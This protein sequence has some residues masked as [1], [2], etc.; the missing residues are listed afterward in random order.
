M[1]YLNCIVLF[2]NLVIRA[3]SGAVF[4]ALVILSILAP[5]PYYF[6]V[7]FLLIALLGLRE[8]YS[9]TGKMS[10]V[11]VNRLI[12]ML[13]GVALFSAVFANAF[14]LLP[15]KCAYFLYAIYILLVSVAF[16]IELFRVKENPIKNIAIS[17]MGQ[18]YIL[19]PICA[20]TILEAKEPI[21]L[22]AFFI[23][24]W[25]SD[26]G[27]YLTGMCFGKHKMFERVSP[28]KTWEGLFGGFVFSLITAY[29]FNI[30][31]ED[32]I[33]AQPLWSWILFAVVVFV[34]GT[35]GDLIE[36][37]FKRT[38]NVKDSGSIMPGHGGVLDRFDSALLAAPL[39]V[40]LA[41]CVF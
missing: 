31:T 25:A 20:M 26:T 10:Q 29:V 35:L 22:L 13:A 39:A 9:L 27:A 30:V 7:L 11:S 32:S 8:F 14:N 6:G 16:I 21:Y 18:F 12:P 34:A 2:K 37:L 5:M 4:V 28:K 41:Y 38:L 1:S 17:V 36:S 24:I 33:A 15:E 40:A 19:F 3:I 23:T